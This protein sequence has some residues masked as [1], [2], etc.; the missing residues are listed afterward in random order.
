MISVR[1][2]RL[3]DAAVR[4][5]AVLPILLSCI[6]SSAIPGQVPSTRGASFA[7]LSAAQI[8]S[9]AHGMAVVQTRD[10]PH[11]P[12]PRVRI[13]LFIAACPD[14]GAAVLSD[15]EHQPAY[16]KQLIWARVA[17][18]PNRA[19]AEVRFR[20]RVP[21]APDIEYTVLDSVARTSDGGFEVGWRLVRSEALSEADGSATF[22]PWRNPRNGVNGTML[23][24]EHFVVPRSSLARLAPDRM[25]RRDVIAAT[26]AI[27]G[28]IE[29][30]RSRDSNR[31]YK[32]VQA[33]RLATSK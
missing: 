29:R 28:E 18:R 26:R 33:L 3:A 6:V 20:Y 8:D 15:Y 27:A 10:V 11:A 25:A 14:E 22:L 21:I 9:V 5:S 24:Y 2:T 16:M 13:V 30:E 23:L 12:W 32:Q 1:G 7:E 17:S 4:S 19:S 31:L